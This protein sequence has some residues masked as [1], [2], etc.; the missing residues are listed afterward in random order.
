MSK[1]ASE[2]QYKVMSLSYRGKEIFKPLNTGWIDERV[3]CVREFVANIFFYTKGD[4]TIM[5]D[6][7]YNYD[8][9]REKMAWLDI[10]PACIHD[11]FVTHQDTDHVGAIERDSPG[12]F[13]DATIYV[14]EIEN[15]YLTGEVRRNVYWGTYKLPQVYIDNHKELLA[16]GQVVQVGDIKVEALLVPGHTYGHLVYLVDDAYLF[17][18]DTIWFGPDGG[19]SFLNTL[20]EDNAL[21]LRSL[22]QLEDQLRGRGL[23]PKVITGHTG[24]SSDLDFVFA[25]TDEV[26]HAFFKQKPHDPK[27]P[28]DA[29][30]EDDDTEEAARAGLLPEVE[31]VRASGEGAGF[32][33]RVAPLYDAAMKAGD[34]GLQEAVAYVASFVH[35][36]DVVLD[37]ACGTGA[38]ACG[39]APAAG[40]AAACDFA[41]RMVARASAKAERLGLQNV[42]CGT[43]DLMA[44]DFADDT[45][46][47]AVA[48]NVLHLLSN[49]QAAVDE[50]KRV[51]RPGGII[52]VPNYVNAQTEDRR[53]LNLAEAVGFKTQHEWDEKG[54]LA[55]L[56]E[57]GLKVT[58]SR[59]FDARQPLVVAICTHCPGE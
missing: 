45:F 3:A 39:I 50:L 24:W 21:S 23:A 34:A 1:Q 4:T 11:I 30:V 22:A 56:A 28:Y 19:Y 25:H 54:Y 58:E 13:R 42:A 38:F 12:L 35:P 47:M 16:D 46:D 26:C 52:A 27:A 33:N 15:R 36:T 29:Y 32:W 20:A 41:P 9:L 48:G 10:D 55:F 5:I 18:G 57:T 44:L 37:A 49:P 6:A 53:F 51:T 8:R 14:G 40:F 2:L 7:G 31:P 43:G 17:T 59:H